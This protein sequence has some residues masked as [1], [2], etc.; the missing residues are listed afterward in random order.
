MSGATGNIYFGLHEFGDMAFM[1][2]FLRPGDFLLDIG[3]NVGTYTVLAGKICQAQVMAFEPEPTT[4][5]KLQRNI[6]ANEINA[7]ARIE[8]YALGREAGSIG[9]TAGLDAMNHVAT[10]A[11]E[12]DQTVPIKRLDDVIFPQPPIMIK[13]DVEGHED[14]AFE[15]AEQTLAD[16]ALLA[17]EAETVSD[18]AHQK[19]LD[20]GFRRHY[21][22]PVGRNISLNPVEFPA[23]NRLYI[24]NSDQVQDRV[25]SSVP[26]DLFGWKI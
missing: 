3:A 24:R 11:A 23:N 21:Y 26:I 12:A 9:F 1:L 4:A 19:F 18:S 16:P 15:G 14:A 6:E 17:I 20:L 13:I 2:H 8:R 5:S 25:S 7:L 22:D 10:S